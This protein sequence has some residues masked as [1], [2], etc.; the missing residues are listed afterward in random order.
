MDSQESLEQKNEIN[1]DPN[2]ID[3]NFNNQSNQIN[4]IQ[5]TIIDLQKLSTQYEI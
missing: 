3:V 4:E 2:T 5:E 1:E